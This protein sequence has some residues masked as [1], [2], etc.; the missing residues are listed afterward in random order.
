MAAGRRSVM[1]PRNLE[2]SVTRPIWYTTLR[3]WRDGGVPLAEPPCARRAPRLLGVGRRVGTGARGL[4]SRPV[5]EADRRRSSARPRSGGALGHERPVAGCAHRAPPCGC[6]RALGPPCAGDL[7]ARRAA[8]LDRN[9]CRR[10]RRPHAGWRAGGAG[11]RRSAHRRGGSAPARRVVDAALSP[12]RRGPCRMPAARCAC[13]GSRPPAPMRQ[14]S[15][16]IS[17]PARLLPCSPDRA[18]PASARPLLHLC[19]RSAAAGRAR[20]MREVPCER[21]TPPAMPARAQLARGE[22]SASWDARRGSQ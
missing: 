13:G 4:S 18:R 5:L 16:S 7:G 1:F 14:S 8:A 15:A 17:P 9:A 22:T 11:A 19:L 20:A 6:A 2:T 21:R 3:R 10:Y 12:G